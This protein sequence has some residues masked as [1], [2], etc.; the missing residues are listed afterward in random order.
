MIKKCILFIMVLTIFGCGEVD[1]T[2]LQ[3]RNGIYYMINSKEPFTGKTKNY[4]SL[5]NIKEEII[6]KDGLKNGKY[7][8]YYKN[9]QLKEKSN[10]KDNKYDGEC[11]IYYENGQIA[12]IRNYK[13]GQIEGKYERYYK[14]GQMDVRYN[15]KINKS[16][17]GKF[18]LGYDGEYRSYYENGQV[19]EIKNYKNGQPE[20]KYE[21]Y[22]KNGQLRI[23]S[24]YRNGLL[25]GEYISYYDNGKYEKRLSY[26][27]KLTGKYIS[28]Y[29]NGKTKE[30]IDFKLN[31]NNELDGSNYTSYYENGQ[32]FIVGEFKGLKKI[33]NWKIYYE[34]GEKMIEIKYGKNDDD[35]SEYTSYYENGQ[36]KERISRAGNEQYYENGLLKLKSIDESKILVYNK[37]G[38]IAEIYIDYSGVSPHFYITYPDKNIGFAS[39]NSL[40]RAIERF[41]KYEN[42]SLGYEVLV[43]DYGNYEETSDEIETKD[44]EIYQ[45]FSDGWI[46]SNSQIRDL[47]QQHY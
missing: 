26:N 5:K 9:G 32:I 15:Y 41:L 37:I 42:Y 6:F 39:Y 34:N 19:A 18:K 30:N 31:K 24:N 1:Y 13:N 45:R 4:D 43:D 33:C 40:D 29:K 46:G 23:I 2:K 14:N 11:R 12:E 22:Y 17:N 28:Y 27:G 35:L 20:G 38:E 47:L 8:L 25:N 10:Y 16:A 21:G 7:K 44:E 3:N 36:V